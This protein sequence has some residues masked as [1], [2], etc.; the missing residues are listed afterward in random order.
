[1]LFGAAD[2]HIDV[3]PQHRSEIFD[4]FAI[5]PSDIGA[6]EL[7]RASQVRHP[8]LEADARAQRRFFE[9]QGHHAAGQDRLTN[10]LGEFRL[11]ILRDDEHALDLG[12]GQLE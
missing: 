8:R 6:E 5:A 3:L 11:E 12:R 7:G 1:M 9:Q 10:P 2:N 4:R